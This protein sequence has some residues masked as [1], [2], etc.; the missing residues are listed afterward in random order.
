MPQYAGELQEHLRWVTETTRA[1]TAANL[2]VS[3]EGRLDIP[4]ETKMSNTFKAGESSNRNHQKVAGVRYS[5]PFGD[6]FRT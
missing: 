6:S 3:L 5:R 1:H 4:E 2:S